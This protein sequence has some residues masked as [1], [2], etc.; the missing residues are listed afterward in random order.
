M[1]VLSWNCRGLGNSRTVREV[2]DLVSRKKPEFV[3]LMEA[4]VGR[5]HAERLRV[6]LGYEGLFYV[7]NVGLSGGLALLW[8]KN[9]TARLLSY[10]RNHVDVEVTIAGLE[11]W[12]M[13]CY[14]GFPERSRRRDSWDL[15]RS[16]AGRS[17]LPWV[18]VGDFNDLL[19][20]SE[21]RGGN[22]H[23]DALLRGFGEA[24]DDCSLAQLPMRGYQFTWERGRGTGDWLE[25]RL[26]KVMV[27]DHWRGMREGAFVENILTRTSDHSALF[28]CIDG[29]PSAVGTGRV[30]FRFKMAWLLDE[31]CREVVESAWQEGRDGGL[32]SCVNLCGIRL[33]RWGGDHFHKFGER[34][35]HLRGHQ[36][37]LRGLR[38]PASLAEFR[39][40]EEQLARLEAQEDIFW[41]QRAKQH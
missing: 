21:K 10:S 35:R 22:P 33:R 14:Y 18:V 8:R 23:L 36:L 16:L 15:L 39:R 32:M 41:S 1:S 37:Q 9:C 40:V 19:Y 12:R 26:D 28:L 13:T 7:D 20:Q 31:G 25:E 38:D 11:S 5:N 34:I 4:K 30:G 3:F 27:N 24:M 2:M 6:K 17:S 29:S